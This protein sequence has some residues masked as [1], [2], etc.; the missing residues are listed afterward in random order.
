M[1]NIYT[2]VCATLTFRV[3]SYKTCKIWRKY[4]PHILIT[5]LKTDLCWTCQQN[6][7]AITASSNKTDVEKERVN[8]MSL[9]FSLNQWASTFFRC[10]MQLR[11]TLNWLKRREV[12]TRK[13]AR[14]ARK[15][16]KRN[17]SYLL[18]IQH[19]CP[20]TSLSTSVLTLHNKSIFHLTLCS[21]DLY[22]SWHQGSAAYLV[23]AEKG[24][25][26]K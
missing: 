21:L 11:H 22:P 18:L 13:S 24:S 2:K 23:F 15:V 4:T 8:W 14:S 9:S 17:S 12:I 3:A 6:S 25:S 10:W 5:T 1:W 26:C 7:F 16:W 19:P 20:G